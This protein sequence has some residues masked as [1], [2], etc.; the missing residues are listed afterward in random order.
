MHSVKCGTLE[1]Q[2]PFGYA[3]EMMFVYVPCVIYVA[4]N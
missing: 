4:M 1:L 3:R 2:A